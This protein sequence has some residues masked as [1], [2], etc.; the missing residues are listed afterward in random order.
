MSLPSD[1]SLKLQLA[2]L[3]AAYVAGLAAIVAAFLYF[4]G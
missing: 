2:A 1:R 3:A 4:N